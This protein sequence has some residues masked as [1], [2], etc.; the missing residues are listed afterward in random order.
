V[1]PF[2]KFLKEYEKGIEGKGVEGGASG[3]VNVGGVR[4]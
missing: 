3:R 2:W 4:F 1:L